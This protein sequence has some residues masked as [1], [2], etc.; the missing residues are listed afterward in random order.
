MIHKE[1]KAVYIEIPRCASTS[2]RSALG[3]DVADRAHLKA[4]EIMERW[5]Y[6]RHGDPS[7]YYW[8]TFVRQQDDWWQSLERREAGKIFPDQ[9]QFTW[10]DV[11]TSLCEW[12]YGAPVPVQVFD[13]H[14]IED[15]WKI[16]A[17]ILDLGQLPHL[18]KTKD[19]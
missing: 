8:F 3:G 11:T 6:N 1:K 9:W 17:N 14:Q 7:Q 12:L 10:G 16:V 4:Y 5:D 13:Y 19:D 18:N 15:H 2:I